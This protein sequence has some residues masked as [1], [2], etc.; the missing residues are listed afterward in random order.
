MYQGS[1]PADLYREGF[2]WSWVNAF[3][4]L[5]GCHRP[6]FTLFE[7]EK[8]GDFEFKVSLGYFVKPYLKIK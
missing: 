8:P 3:C 2:P 4:E 6:A 7:K 5:N 1:F